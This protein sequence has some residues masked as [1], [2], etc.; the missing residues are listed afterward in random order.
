M[1]I[2]LNDEESK[3]HLEQKI[4]EAILAETSKFP[5]GRKLRPEPLTPEQKAEIQ[6]LYHTGMARG[7]IARELHLPGRQ[8]SGVV[9]AYI[10]SAKRLLVEPVI[11]GLQPMKPLVMPEV[12]V[13]SAK[14][15]CASCGNDLGH[16]KVAIDGKL[17]CSQKCAPKKVP[18]MIT[19][20]PKPPKSNFA[21]DSLIVDM[22]A[23]PPI[24]IADE[25]NRRF[26]GTWLPDDVG[27]RLAELRS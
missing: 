18:T 17:Y 12:K 5:D 27:K 26:G 9:Q 11:E 21:I 15:A 20:R 24:E 22:A 7:Q 16:N 23:R 14:P 4:R 6:R 13:P 8:V 25:I 3:T 1:Q 10:N 2:I 19:R